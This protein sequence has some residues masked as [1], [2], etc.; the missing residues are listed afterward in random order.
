MAAP[1]TTDASCIADA[2]IPTFGMSPQR[3][4]PLLVF[5]VNERLSIPTFLEGICIYER[6]INRIANLPE[7]EVGN[8]PRKYLKIPQDK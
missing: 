8:N 4:T 5:G 2:G 7:S 3:N 1:T 6:V